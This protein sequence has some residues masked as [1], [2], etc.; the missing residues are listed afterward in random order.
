M[1]W[2]LRITFIK[3]ALSIFIFAVIQVENRP[4]KWLLYLAPPKLPNIFTTYNCSQVHN[5]IYGQCV[6]FSFKGKL[7]PPKIY[8][9]KKIHKRTQIIFMLRWLYEKI[10][11]G[12]ICE[13]FKNIRKLLLSSSVHA[14]WHCF[15]K[16]MNQDIVIKQIMVSVQLIKAWV[17]THF[18]N[19]SAIKI[20]LVL[21]P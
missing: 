11:L 5:E 12:S 16:D 1:F 10:R 6:W 20:I 19:C 4:L 3:T 17:G 7:K 8:I 9:W 14:L 2:N 21:L 18:G 13:K 15:W